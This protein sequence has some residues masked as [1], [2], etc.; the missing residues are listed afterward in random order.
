MSYPTIPEP[1]VGSKDSKN[2]PLITSESEGSY[3]KVRR[4]STKALNSFT[5]DYTSITESEFAILDAYFETYIGTSFDFVHP[6][7]N[8]TYSCT[9][10]TETLEKTYLAG[11]FIS[12]SVKLMEI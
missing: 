9:F 6:K 5:L 7:T 12:T 4:R 11:G 3:K 1:R 8:V 2:I 10:E